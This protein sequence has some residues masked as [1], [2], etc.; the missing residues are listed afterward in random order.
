MK[1]HRVFAL[2]ILLILALVWG[3]SFIL[4]K[5]GLSV[6]EPVQVAALRI[7]LAGLVLSPF[8]FFFFRHIERRLWKYLLVVGLT[9]SGV[10][11]LLFCIAQTQIHSSTAGLLNS[12]S[13]LFVMLVG[14]IFFRTRVSLWQVAGV[15]LGL[16]GA[17][18]LITA[19]RGESPSGEFWYGLLVVAA[20]VCYGF[21][22]NVIKNRL[23]GLSPLQINSL[24]F[25]PIAPPY[26]VYLAFSDFGNRL[27]SHAGAWQ[28]LGYVSILAIVGTVISNILYT[29]L[30]K[31]SSAIFASSVTYL[32]PII[33]LMWGVLDGEQITELHGV[34]IVVILTGIT[35]INKKSSL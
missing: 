7:T 34:G 18:F 26:M 15:I 16:C 29:R 12:L 4:M 24:L 32:M 35:L 1:S 22:A 3:S 14:I 25:L 13:P 23:Q 17:I 31:I 9:G 20:T 27:Q 5:R 6:F 11:A 2:L 33:A 28:A 19:A 10:P 30:I 8:S 21:S